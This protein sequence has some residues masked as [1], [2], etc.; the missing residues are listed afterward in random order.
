MKTAISLLYIFIVAIVTALII[1]LISVPSGVKLLAI[2]FVTPFVVLSLIFV[3]FCRLKKAWSFAGAS[4][5]GAAGAILRAIVNT[6]PNLEV[7]GGLPIGVTV[8]YIMI[9]T[10]L[11]L[12]SYESLLEL[13]G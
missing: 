7:A 4:I 8:L 12:K 6:R 10:L 3:H 1:T 9:G 2:V 13:R 5:L 11:S